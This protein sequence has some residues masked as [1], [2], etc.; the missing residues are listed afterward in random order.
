[1]QSMKQ[2]DFACVE[3]V[4]LM[5]ELNARERGR[6]TKER[7]SDGVESEEGAHRSSDDVTQSDMDGNRVSVWFDLHHAQHRMWW[8]KGCEEQEERET[9]HVMMIRG[10]QGVG[11]VAKGV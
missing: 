7:E 2:Y 6:D 4:F 5:Q 9:M 1:M 8:Q 3:V 11:V 10:S